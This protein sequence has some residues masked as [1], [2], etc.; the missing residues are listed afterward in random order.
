[1]Q[2]RQR[3]R[4]GDSNAEDKAHRLTDDEATQR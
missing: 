4:S 3:E 1:M 2:Q